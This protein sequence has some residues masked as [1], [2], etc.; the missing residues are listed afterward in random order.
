MLLKNVFISA[1]ENY[2]SLADVHFHER[3]KKI[4]YK[5]DKVHWI[6]ID[7]IEKRKKI[8][9]NSVKKNKLI[10][11]D[12]LDG[13]LNLLVPGGIDSHVHFNT[14]GFEQREDFDHASLAAAIGGTTTI[15]DMP[16]TSLPPVTNRENLLN[17]NKA[18]LGRS[19]VDY[20]F[21]GGVRG[22]DF[23]S[24]SEI[25]EQI[26]E[27]AD[28]GVAGFKAYFIS[29]METFEDLSFDQMKETA[30]IT[31]K[32][33]MP[34]AVHA[35]DKNLVITREKS[36]KS[37][38]K[39]SWADYCVSRDVAAELEAVSNMIKIAKETKARIHIV[40]LS[41]KSALELIRNAK[42]D[43]LNVTAETCPHYLYFTQEHFKNEK[44]RNSLKTAPPVKLWEDR[45]ALWEGLK[46]GTLEFVVTD[47][48]GSD[49][50]RDKSSNNFWEVYGGIPGVE[51]RVPFLFSEGF[52][53]NK[54]T[55]EDT[56]KLLSSRQADYYN[57]KTKGKIE[58]GFDADFCLLNL[59]KSKK[60]SA[61]NMFCKGKQ[62]PFEGVNLNAVVE[63]T[64]LRGEIIEEQGNKK[65]STKKGMFIKV[66]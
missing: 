40:H 54:L 14:P 4:E 61:E 60:I 41:S 55:L 18:L 57:L 44:I 56:I 9:D 62:T 53:K 25:K 58:V 34:L 48:A 20:A 10:A 39:N 63:A 21:W 29:C 8:L 36:L 66:N 33:N 52:L 51:H 19:F 27:L 6:D 64:F 37:Q 11:G 59:W 17:K 13:K 65:S 43:G 50:K 26:Y 3:I 23:N 22:S 1:Y 42:K 35:E 46:D 31:K 5:S 28:S 2:L 38:N 15:I 16:C 47:H 45:E 24:K 30:F 49:P 12:E 32:T 7:T